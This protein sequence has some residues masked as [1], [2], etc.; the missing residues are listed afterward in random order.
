MFKQWGNNA[1]PDESA[2]FS[3]WTLY[4]LILVDTVFYTLVM[5]GIIVTMT[6][7]GSMHM[8]KKFDND[9][10]APNSES[11]W[12]PRFLF[13]NGIGFHIGAISGSYG[14]LAI[15]DSIVSGMPIPLVP[16]LCSVL[17]DVGLCCLMFKCFD[18]AHEPFSADDELEEDSF[19]I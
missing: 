11:V 8:R 2:P 9:A 12:T 17:V 18:S 3:Y 13:V 6:R 7:K 10:H 1:Q 15:I 5:L 16:L 14:S 19:F 4:F